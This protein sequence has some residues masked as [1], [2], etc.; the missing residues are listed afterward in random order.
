[1]SD[2]AYRISAPE[3]DA[4]RAAAS[5]DAYPRDLDD[6]H[7]RLVR[8][9]EESEMARQDE[10]ALAE[11]DRSYVDHEQWTR[12]E[13]KLLKERGQPAIVINKIAD[14]LQLLCGMERKARTDPKAFART[15]AEEDRAD[16]ATQALRYIADDNSFSLVRSGVFENMLVEG[17]GGAELGLEDD[18]QGGANITITHVPWD[19]VWYDPHSRSLDFSDARYKGLVIWTDRDQLEADYPDADDVIEAS[20]SSVDFHYN[21]RPETAFWTDNNRRRIRLVQ[22]HWDERGT[23]WQATYT[24]HGLLAK[25]QRSRFKDRKGKSCCGLILQSS[26]INRDNQR[27]GMVRGLI[28]LQDEINKRRS[29]ALHLLSVRQVVAEQG[30]VPDVDK[31]RREVA[32]PDGYIEVM[33][34]LKFEIEQTADLAAGQFQLLQHA[35]AEMQLSGP[36]AAMSGTDPRELSGRAIL[37]QQAGGA[38]QNEP[39]ADSL[40]YWSRR[41]YESCWMA[42]REY[43]T[44]GKWVRVTDD[45]NETRWVGI[46][47]P[48]RLM[49]KLADMPERQRAPLMQ[50]L[51][52]V[53]NDPRLQQVIDIENDIT[54][55]DVDITISEGI[56]IPSLQAEQFQTLVQL[57][58]MQPGLIPGDVLIAASGLKD[59]DM[60]LERMKEHQQQQQQAQQKAGQMA[61]AHATADIQGKQA[62][63]AADFAL[64]QER[65][66]NAAA[67]V[68]AVHG[69]FSAPPYGQPNVAPDNPPGASQAMQQ[70]DP[71]QMTPD[72]A[73]ASHLADLEK[74]HADISK[75]RADTLLTAAK[76]P[77]TAQQTLH[78]AHQTHQTAVTTNRLLRTPIPQP[79]PQ[80]GA[81]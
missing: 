62:K 31:A 30:A 10:I 48:V 70:P 28:S 15:P 8:W 19:R 9:F 76:I 44:G 67:G 36:N 78:T 17:A 68:H 50:R 63:A 16:A 40:R 23:W 2:T 26:Y 61:E 46:N 32:K 71:E 81:P 75:T 27:Y 55:L 73:L 72:I 66:V 39:L 6:L 4:P 47:R 35:T 37:A 49:D 77:Q 41:V 53:P 79:A 64:A 43:W 80:G 11:R 74:K 54:D 38:A 65:K 3:D 45:L 22:C 59:K 21:D 57:A 13:L 12:E 52:L 58:G 56:D 34:G 51:Q 69:E 20:F 7:D 33:P 18:G 5:A 14:K 29:K 60:L 42:A 1:M 25:P 24:K